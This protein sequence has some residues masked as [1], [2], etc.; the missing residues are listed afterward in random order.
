MAKVNAIP[1]G[2]G[3]VT[4]HII[5]RDA[6]RALDFYKKAFGA[7][8]RV[9]MPGPGGKIVHAEMQIGNSIVM[10]SD[11]FP[12]MASRSP[13]TL[14]GSPG[15]LMLYTE[16]CDRAYHRALQAGAT[17]EMAPQDMF[18]G[19]RYGKVRDPFGHLW[20][21]GTHIEDVT[22]EEIGKRQQAFMAQMQKQG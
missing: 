10:L 16:D 17:S 20:A 7:E 4:P 9:R 1:H 8:E 2:Y 14:G 5:V 15:G 18:W 6:A 12:E 19:D 11:E 3:T 21:I 22:P 13:Q